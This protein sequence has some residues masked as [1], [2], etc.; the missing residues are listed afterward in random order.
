[1]TVFKDVFLCTSMSFRTFLAMQDALLPAE[2]IKQ[3]RPWSCSA[4]EDCQHQLR[5]CR[6]RVRRR[7]ESLQQ[8]ADELARWKD[9]VHTWERAVAQR[10]SQINDMVKQLNGMNQQIGHLKSILRSRDAEMSD[11]N[12]EIDGMNREMCR[13]TRKLIEKNATVGYYRKFAANNSTLRR[14]VREAQQ[15]EA[16]AKQQLANARK[17]TPDEDDDVSPTFSD[18]DPLLTDASFKRFMR[19]FTTVVSKKRKSSMTA[20]DF[21]VIVYAP[22]YDEAFGKC[23]VP[24]IDEILD[25]CHFDEVTEKITCSLSASDIKKYLLQYATIKHFN[26]MYQRFQKFKQSS[27]VLQ[28]LWDMGYHQAKDVVRG[29]ERRNVP[30]SDVLDGAWKSIIF[31]VQPGQCF[32]SG[33]PQKGVGDHIQPVRANR[34]VTGCYGGNSKWNLAP[35]ISALN[36]PYKNMVLFLPDQG[37][38]HKI[39]LDN[40]TF[41]NVS[42]ADFV[43]HDEATFHSQYAKKRSELESQRFN[44]I[45]RLRNYYKNHTH[46]ERLNNVILVRNSVH[47]FRLI[48]QASTVKVELL[49]SIVA[50]P[51]CSQRTHIGKFLEALSKQ[52]AL[53]TRLKAAGIEVEYLRCLFSPTRHTFSP[54]VQANVARLFPNSTGI[55]KAYRALWTQLGLMTVVDFFKSSNAMKFMKWMQT[56][57]NKNLYRKVDALDIY[58]R[59]K[60][61]Q[62]YVSKKSGAPKMEW[63]MSVED[64]DRIEDILK[65]GVQQIHVGTQEFIRENAADDLE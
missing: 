46:V 25:E 3:K 54:D 53:M 6:D 57:E 59:L 43:F 44:C 64:F 33:D 62:T 8:S 24:R 55:K 22:Y 17:C 58:M 63:E 20:N 1:M 50:L 28:R 9:A 14:Q 35:V 45:V 40:A 30:F 27:Y 37:Q 52:N 26:E 11:M 21:V 15:N 65:K 41:S 4:L 16:E 60:L 38:F 42:F 29:L 49:K 10:D 12:L 34:H 32:V 18:S 31:G 23:H 61:W 47:F 19:L 7:N 56:K 39:C 2:P 13:L 48:E 51:S 36:Q 5:E